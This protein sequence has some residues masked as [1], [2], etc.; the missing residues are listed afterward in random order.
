MDRT[1]SKLIV[2]RVLSGVRA[3]CPVRRRRCNCDPNVQ[4]WIHGVIVESA[5]DRRLALR[6]VVAQGNVDTRLVYRLCHVC[7]VDAETKNTSIRRAGDV[8]VHPSGTGLC[9]CA[10]TGF[11]RAAGGC[12]A[13]RACKDVKHRVEVVPMQLLVY[14]HDD[15]SDESV[16]SASLDLRQGLGLGHNV[17]FADCVFYRS[18]LTADRTADKGQCRSIG[19]RRDV[20]RRVGDRTLQS[21]VF[22]LKTS[23]EIRRI[24]TL[25]RDAMPTT[26][27]E[28]PSATDPSTVDRLATELSMTHIGVAGGSEQKVTLAMAPPLLTWAFA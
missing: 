19:I 14:F 1:R 17:P 24:G 7:W 26:A 3:D 25:G 8:A 22:L 11:D 15:I 10:G 16:P 21:G 27:T 12:C 13:R 18:I 2:L 5:R 20:A 23:R 6:P 4:L 28:H 9:S